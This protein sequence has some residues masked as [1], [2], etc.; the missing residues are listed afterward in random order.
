MSSS[1]SFISAHALVTTLLCALFAIMYLDR[2]NI[3]AAAASV[4]AHFGLTNTEMGLIFSGFSWAYLASV[5]LGGWGARKFGARSTLVVCVIVVGLGTIAT[6]LAG[7]V[8]SFFIRAPRCRLRRG[9]G[10]S[11]CNTGDAQL[12]SASSALDYIQGIT[13][14]ASRL[15]AAL[16]PPVVAALI[17]WGDWQAIVYDLWRRGTCLVS[18]MVGTVSR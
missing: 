6:G 3:S 1:R 10:I 13:H 18:A 4:K 14:S 11:G 16:A 8:I 2:V 12:V 5:L 17:A 7:G 9:A 15:G